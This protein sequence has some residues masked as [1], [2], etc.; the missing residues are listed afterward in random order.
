LDKDDIAPTEPSRTSG[1]RVA[2][3]VDGENISHHLA[4]R[5]LELAGSHGRMVMRCVFGDMTSPAIKGWEAAAS[6]RTVHAFQD[7]DSADIRLTVEAM[8]VAYSGRADAFVIA[9]SDTGLAHL[10]HHPNEMGFP[11]PR[12]PSPRPPQ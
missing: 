4:G 7:E 11:D 8:A 1:P 3:F 10:A 6:V 12:L 5:I 9:T 2:L